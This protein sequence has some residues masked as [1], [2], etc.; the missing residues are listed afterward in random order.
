MK[1]VL[2]KWNRLYKLQRGVKRSLR[3]FVRVV[4]M[5]QEIKNVNSLVEEV[6]K[7]KPITR[8]S[9]MRLILEVWEKEGVIFSTEQKSKIIMRCS[10]PESIT[11][12]RRKFQE[13]GWYLPSE[14]IKKE[15]VIEEKKIRDVFSGRT[16][17]L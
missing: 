7:D 9:D 15:R 17:M 1:D 4:G 16:A 12:C 3:N 10:A 8:A 13:E 11:R 14:Q 2:R 5:L 6:L